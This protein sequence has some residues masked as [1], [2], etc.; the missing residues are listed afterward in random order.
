MGGIAEICIALNAQSTHVICMQIVE[1][2]KESSI[3]V[4]SR[5]IYQE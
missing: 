2:I 1:T 5:E 4:Q 3:M